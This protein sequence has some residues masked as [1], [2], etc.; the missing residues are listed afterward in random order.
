MLSKASRI[1]RME[2]KVYLQT[3]DVAAASCPAHLVS[4]HNPNS[5]LSQALKTNLW[6]GHQFDATGQFVKLKNSHR[7]NE[8]SHK[9]STF[10]ANELR[11]KYLHIWNTPGAAGTISRLEGIHADTVRRYKRLLL[12]ID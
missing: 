7:A 1:N 6:Q 9:K 11:Q 10:K 2:R 8:A 5:S 3:L 4:R 12:Y